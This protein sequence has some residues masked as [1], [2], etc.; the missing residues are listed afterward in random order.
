MT[1]TET[2]TID[3]SGKKLGRVA[4]EAAILLMGKARTDFEKHEIAPVKVE[5]LNASKLNLP[6]KKQV[7][8]KYIRYSG[9]P[10]GL[11]EESLE[12]LITRSGYEEVVW[13]AIYGMLPANKL[14]NE[15]MKQVEVKK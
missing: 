4:S 10:G 7:E 8:K 3:A 5:I 2:H 1:K 12:H 9:H 6:E 14:R 13:R 15:L 11:K